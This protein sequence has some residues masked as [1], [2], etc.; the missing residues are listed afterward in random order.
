MSPSSLFP[1]L[2]DLDPGFVW[3]AALL[4]ALAYSVRSAQRSH[5]DPRSMYWAV[6]F[7]ILGGLCGGHLLGLLVHG[8]QG[9]PLAFFQFWQGGKSYYG[10]LV[11]GDRWRTVLSLPKVT[12]PNLRGCEYARTRTGIRHRSS[13]LFSERRRLRDGVQRIL[14]R[15]VSSRHG[16]PRRPR[17]PRLDQPGSDVVAARSSCPVVRVGL[18]TGPVRVVCELASDA[19]GQPFLCV[20]GFP[21]R[22]SFLHGMAT[23]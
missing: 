17:S 23:R 18:G 15:C 1:F 8:W 13:G 14:G 20:C 9:G 2:T 12:C 7:A 5:L 21:R 22:G 19:T 11:G 4:A 3:A 6:V 16:G 10:G